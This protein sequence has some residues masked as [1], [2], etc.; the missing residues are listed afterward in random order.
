MKKME[1]NNVIVECIQIA[2]DEWN[3][4]ADVHNQWHHLP[5]EEKMELVMDEVYKEIR[6]ELENFEG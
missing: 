6:K 2:K 3:S 1:N 5:F 4:G